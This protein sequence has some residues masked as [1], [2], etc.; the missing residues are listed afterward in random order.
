[1]SRQRA[2]ALA[3]NLAHRGRLLNLFGFDGEAGLIPRLEAPFQGDGTKSLV[4]QHERRPGAGF[5]VESSAVGDDGGRLGQLPDSVSELF[6]SD[7]D[8]TRDCLMHQGIDARGHDVQEKGLARFN[9]GLGLFR[10]DSQLGVGG[11]QRPGRTIT[12]PEQV[13]TS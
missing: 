8:S 9:H 11:V 5:L 2:A 3:A 13:D 7:A 12:K 6:R 4:S 1:M 10:C